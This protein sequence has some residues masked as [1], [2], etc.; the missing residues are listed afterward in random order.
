[1]PETATTQE[2]AVLSTGTLQQLQLALRA[3]LAT[4]LGNGERVP[5]LVDDAL[6]NADD[7][8]AEAALLQAATLARSGQQIVFFTH[9]EALEARA[10]ALVGVTV[11]RLDGPIAGGVPTPGGDDDHVRYEETSDSRLA[12]TSPEATPAAGAQTAT[13]GTPPGSGLLPGF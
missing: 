12:T 1:V 5:L 13:A 8:R 3:A 10:S 2:A 7:G 4:T 9:R 11:V 6:A